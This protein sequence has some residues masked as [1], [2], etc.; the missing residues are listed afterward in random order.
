LFVR[1]VLGLELGDVVR[2]VEV[3][4]GH[5]VLNR[6]IGKP[7]GEPMSA[8]ELIDEMHRVLHEARWNPP[9]RLRDQNA[10]NA[11]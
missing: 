7:S 2:F 11:D 3:E 4:P 5:F 10:K 1:R 8:N 9:L 6:K